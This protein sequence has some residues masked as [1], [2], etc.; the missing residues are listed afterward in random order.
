M[1]DSCVMLFFAFIMC[2]ATTTGE[3]EAEMKQ[4]YV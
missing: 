3:V 4:F 2:V 1:N